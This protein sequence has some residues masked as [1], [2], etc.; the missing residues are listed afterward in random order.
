LETVTVTVVQA[1][2]EVAGGVVVIVWVVVVVAGTVVVVAAG[3]VVVVTAG[4]VVVVVQAGPSQLWV[5]FCGHC[6][7]SELAGVVML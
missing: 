5:V 7:P 1:G 2:A 4:T 6:T 3:T